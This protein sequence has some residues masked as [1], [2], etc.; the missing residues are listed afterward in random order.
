MSKGVTFYFVRHGETY[1]NLYNHMQ[2]WANAPL[3]P[4]GIANVH[5]SGRGL[6]DIE[7]DA[8]YTSDLQRTI[9]T[10]EIILQENHGKDLPITPM[11]EFREVFFGSF[12]GRAAK[13]VWPKIVDEVHIKYDLPAGDERDIRMTLNTIKELDPFHH[14]ESY[15]EFWNR[16]ESGLLQLLNKHAGTDQN[17]LVVCH[18][19]TIRNLLSGLVADFNE[20]EP[21][22]NASVSIVEYKDGQ[23]K[24]MAY[25]RTD[26]F[27]DIADD[28]GDKEQ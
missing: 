18:G 11:K 15:P 7:F 27:K 19:M 10:A 1:L 24:M 6:A 28:A 3:T 22:D 20:E 23:F 14:A 16:V 21:L 9:D 8:V 13:D 2:G 26:H 25:G 12:E 17:I 5:R 4:E